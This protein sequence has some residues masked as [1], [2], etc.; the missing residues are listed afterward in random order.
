MPEFAYVA[1]NDAGDDVVGSLS[2]A[3]KR[4][5][6]CALSDRSLFPLRVKSAEPSRFQWKRKQRI[7]GELLA[8]NL[9]QL[10]DL[11][12]NGVALLAAL[13]I[14]VEQCTN[15]SLAEVLSDIRDQVVDGASLD[16]AISR[17]T[18]TFD[19]LTISMVRAGCEGAFLED[20]L[21]R[22]ADFLELQEELK[23]RVTGAMAYP[24][25]LAVFGFLVTV[26]LVVFFVP[27][28]A[29]LFE[30]LEQ[31]G[32]LPGAT[33]ALLW[34]SDTLSAY[35]ILLIAAAVGFVTWA[36]KAAKTERGR[37]FVDR[38]KIR[39][40][41]VGKIYLGS[42]VSR[43][44]RVLGTLLRN[45]VPLLRALEIS[46]D[47]TGN[48]VL[49]QAIRSAAENI[50][51]GDSLSRPL[52]ECGLIPGPVMAMIKVAEE[53]NNLENVLIN[54]A[55]GIDRKTNRQLDIVVRLV[56]PVM[57]MVMG[58]V[59]MFVLVALLLPVFEMSATMN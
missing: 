20:A 2:A 47:S 54:V 1:R 53:S 45:G 23:G 52:Q 37:L 12:Q 49:A 39:I 43:F 10:A 21:K 8:S 19:E 22:T 4:E 6:L 44:C 29:E 36:R 59:I 40:P 26:V 56:E 32:G 27:K 35:G 48:M 5:A 7:T 41:I 31:Q 28:F 18:N 51:S 15:E 58:T 24:A 16:D 9:G 55:D 57:L 46:Q 33:V 42:A 25:F 14:L 17:H 13:E 30:Q 11:L 38:A 34:L 3:N 50:S